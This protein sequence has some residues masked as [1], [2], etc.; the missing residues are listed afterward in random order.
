MGMGKQTI[1]YRY[2][3]SLQMGLARGPLDEIVAIQ[4][5]GLTAWDE[6]MCHADSDDNLI[7]I[8]KPDLFGGDKKEGGVKGPLRVYWGERTQTLAG[9]ISTA[10]GKLPAIRTSLGGLVP[11]FRGVTTLWFDGLIAAMNPYPKEWKVRVRRYRSGWFNDECWYPAKAAIYLADEAGKTIKAMNGAHIIYECITNPEWSIGEDVATLDENSFVAAANTMCAEGLGLCLKWSR[12]S[13]VGEFVKTVI[14]H[15][16]GAL[17][18]D[19]ETGLQTLKLIRN[20]YDPDD[21]PLFTP[22]TGLLSIVEDDSSSQDEAVS[23]VIV[24]YRDP[25]TNEDR[26]VRAQSTGAW[27]TNLSANTVTSELPGLPNKSIAGRRAL[28]ELRAVTAGL[29]RYKVKLDRRGYK[30]TPAGVFK[31]SDPA[32]GI[33]AVILRAG[34]IDDSAMDGDGSITI[35]AVEDVFGFPATAFVSPEPSGWTAP[36]TDAVVPPDHRLIELGYRDLAI[37]LSAADAAAVEP[38][39]AYIGELAAAPNATSLEFD[40][41]TKAT[42]E[43][44][45]VNQKTGS[46]CACATLAADITPLQTV[47]TLANE[48]HFADDII[49]DAAMIGNEVVRIDAYDDTAHLMTV[50]RGC[51][52]SIPAAHAAGVRVWLLDDDMVGDERIYAAGET[53]NAKALTRTSSDVLAEADAATDS[54][55]LI[56]RADRPYPVA[57]LKVAASAKAATSIYLLTGEWDLPTLTWVERNRVTQADVLVDHTAA[58]VAA[59]AGTTYTIRV[60]G[61]DG[62][63]LLRTVAGAVSPWTYDA[64]MQTADGNPTKVF[65]EVEAVRGGKVSR[66]N[67]HL[68]ILI[69]SGYGYGYGYD[70]GGLG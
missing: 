51:A 4:V 43:P 2:Y 32:K 61:T 8:N 26:S 60:Y 40:L 57:N 68:P 16:Q 22:D 28:A 10:V 50:A 36:P 7:L 39:D 13:E 11:S 34:E 69:L 25:V 54:V 66:D 56:G 33:A 53:I 45:F 23:E 37:R 49:G 55:V 27:Q 24:K 46:F 30:I 35:T 59:E 14:D 65:V 6:G 18:V 15:I 9:A 44:A 3:F 48:Q 52:D 12:E 5:G 63:T 70:Y 20:D 29:K 62:V 38:D 42:G 31:V 58:G 21:L 41:L 17:Y 47:I 67:Y 64:T 1:G 19:R